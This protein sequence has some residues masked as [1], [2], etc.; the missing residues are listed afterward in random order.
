M[1]YLHE[2]ARKVLNQHKSDDQAASSNYVRSAADDLY[3]MQRQSLHHI[4]LTVSGREFFSL[5]EG[6]FPLIPATLALP[7]ILPYL[8]LPFM[9]LIC[10]GRSSYLYRE[11]FL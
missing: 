5:A 8:I 1:L 6:N 2:I 9:F 4:L 11:K 10:T 3:A 7:R